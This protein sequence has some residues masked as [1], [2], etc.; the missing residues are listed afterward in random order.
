M[1]TRTCKTCG[2]AKPLSTEHF[3]LLSGGTWRWTC[4]V[5]MAAAS[6]RHHA[7]NP[8]KTKARR[9]KYKANHAA[10]EGAYTDA[11]VAAIRAAQG[12]R[13]FYCP[14]DLNGGGELDHKTP[15]SRGGTHWP[16]NL[17]LA[18]LGCNRDKHAKTAEEFFEWR[19]RLGLPVAPRPPAL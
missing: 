3:N 8:E 7:A 2:E 1:N 19:Q 16:E 11:D 9:D 5:C 10:A 15:L 13:C 4:K 12:D 6:R 17:A 14:R 18:C